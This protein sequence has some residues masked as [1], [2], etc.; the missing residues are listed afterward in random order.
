MISPLPCPY[1]LNVPEEWRTAAFQQMSPA[2]KLKISCDLS[3]EYR[4]RWLRSLREWYPRATEAEFRQKV[5]ETLLAE[6]EVEREIAERAAK[7]QMERQA[8]RAAARTPTTT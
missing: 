8:A 4:R 5:I 6:S 2:E 3:T 1:P 7:K